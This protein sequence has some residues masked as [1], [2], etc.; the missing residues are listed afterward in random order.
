[1]LDMQKSSHDQACQNTQKVQ[2]KQKHQYDAEH[3][4][5][6]TMK[7]RDK[8]IVQSKE[9]KGGKLD[10]QFRGPYITEALGKGRFC[11]QGQSG[12]AL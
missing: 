12:A 5:R 2:E 11:L 7:V 8:V 1:M 10:V 9:E 3:N 6:T 4:T